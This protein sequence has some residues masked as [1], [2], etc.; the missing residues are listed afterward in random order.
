MSNRA[1]IMRAVISVLRDEGLHTWF[2][3]RLTLGKEAQRIVS[4]TPDPDDSLILHV[5]SDAASVSL[6]PDHVDGDLVTF[7]LADPQVFRK[8]VSHLHARQRARGS[9]R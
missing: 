2:D 7:E 3:G 9:A 5:S 6:Y 4:L 8:I 1:G